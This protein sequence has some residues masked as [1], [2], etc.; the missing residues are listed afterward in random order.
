M[1]ST[2]GIN[3]VSVLA[4]LLLVHTIGPQTIIVLP[5][6]TQGYVEY[7]G[8]TESF[9]GM[10]ASVEAWGI[11]VAA[12]CMMY[13]IAR[14]RWRL[15]MRSALLAM[16]T[17]NFLSVV[18]LGYTAL[19]AFRFVAG[20]GGGV[21]V[22][23]SYAMIGQTERTQRNFGLAIA[24]VLIYGVF[25]FPLL[26]VLYSV[27]G[28]AGGFGF[29][30]LFACCGVPFVGMLPDHGEDESSD[31]VSVAKERRIEALLSSSVMLIYFIGVMGAWSYF[32]RFGVRAGLEEDS[33]GYALSLSQFAGMAGA[34]AVVLL[35]H[36]LRPSLGAQVG[37]VIAALTIA[38][39]V[40][41]ESFTGFLVL[42][43]VFQFMWNLT[44]P[45]LLSLLALFD[46]SGRIITYGTGMQFLGIAI[47]PSLAALL[48]TDDSLDAV[49]LVCAASTA[50][51][52]LIVA[53]VAAYY[54]RRHGS[55]A[56]RLM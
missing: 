41:V 4:A 23:V 15:L 53:G 12:L 43:F 11:C 24:L 20:F 56:K 50:L 40:M 34:F 5:A 13:L 8:A 19:F 48:V 27:W 25:A 29:F 39:L 51:S 31:N 49:A 3:S 37:I 42:C 47:G 16:A 32:Y 55:T 46:S 52:A 26:S 1:P 33:I 9:A 22:A 18:D 30:A 2:A 44:H 17:A 10:A 38:S 35:E 36:R 28:L 21:I 6:L 45:L 7:R 54:G 14:V